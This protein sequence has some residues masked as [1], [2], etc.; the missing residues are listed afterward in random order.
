MGERKAVTKKL[1]NRYKRATRAEKSVGVDELVGLTGWHRDHARAALRQAG[2]LRPVVPRKPRDPKYPPGVVAALV[3]VWSLLRCPAGKRLAPMLGTVVPLLRR[4]G[5]LSCS[6]G[7]A[8]LL[9]TMSAASIDRH[10]APTRAELGVRG[11]SHTKPGSLLKSQIPVRTWA[12]WDDDRPGFLEIDLVAHEGGNST[13]EFCFT[14]T[15]TDIATGWTV[16]RSVKNK[17]AIWVF[18]ALE[19]VI[20]QFP[21]PILGIDSDNGSEFIN[22]HLFNYCKENHITFTRSRPGNKNDGAHVEQKN[23]THVRELV[24]YL[25][26]DTDSELEVLNQIWELDRTFTNYLLAQQKL[27]HKQRHGA[28]VTKRYD[29]AQTPCQRAIAHA[30][31]T[32]AD[33]ARLAKSMRSVRPG[34]LSRSIAELTARLER[35]ALSKAPAPV[36]PRVNRSFNDSRHP[37]VFGEATN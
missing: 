7:Q 29:R 5:D 23:W 16:N 28:K 33:R 31:L 8:A 2:T 19:H 18:E 9:V 17:A 6:D 15:V 24:G 36:K 37:E 13:G 21:F 10:L 1:A 20:A 11:R 4:D 14:L 22:F 27:V 30:R 25:R 32:K 35:L 12:E 3:V 34:E 26:F